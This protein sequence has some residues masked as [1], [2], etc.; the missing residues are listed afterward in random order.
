MTGRPKVYADVEELK[1]KE[2]IRQW[3]SKL[4]PGDSQLGSL[5]S[6]ARYLRWRKQKGLESDPD[7]IVEECLDG[8]NRTLIK[9]LNEALEY[10]NQYPGKRK[11]VHK[12][13]ERIRSFY[14][15]NH[16]QLPNERLSIKAGSNSLETKVTAKD[17]LSFVTQVLSKAELDLRSRA[18]ILTMLQSG[19]DASTLALSF[20]FYG[21]PQLVRALGEDPAKWDLSKCPIRID[22]IRPKREFRYYTFIDIDAVNA[23]K[24]YITLKRGIPKILPAKPGEMPQSEPLFL[25][26]YDEPISPETISRIFTE[27]GKRA[28]INKMDQRV[29][30][31]EFK[32]ASIRYPFHSHEVR[33]TLVTTAKK[34]GADIMVAN[35]LI[36]HSIDPY[37]YNKSPWD[38]PEHY[39]NEYIKI[40]RPWLNPISSQILIA[41]EEAKKETMNALEEK[42]NELESKLQALLTSSSNL[43]APL[44]SPPD[45]PA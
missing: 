32:Y 42:I 20:N 9:H 10:V 15:H 5:Y 25:N 29:K 33:D 30:L 17:F 31:P 4:A 28:G 41:K 38:D 22:V 27:A 40:A 3:L 16:I 6:F 23:I 24:D 44:R 11:T 2:S 45:Q 14:S 37:G 34:V 35:F 7:K 19:M 18:I 12:Q 13:Y 36:G 43:Q 39:R 21:Y 1:Q 26:Q 8:T